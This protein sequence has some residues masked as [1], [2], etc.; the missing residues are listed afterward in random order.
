[1]IYQEVKKSPS[2]EE[3]GSEKSDEKREGYRSSVDSTLSG[4]SVHSEP[5]KPE[6]ESKLG[7]VEIPKKLHK[8]KS[9]SSVEKET[10]TK[11]SKRSK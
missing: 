11:L 8:E 6:H 3:I 5:M 10:K 1:M 9:E 7:S 2:V 4:T